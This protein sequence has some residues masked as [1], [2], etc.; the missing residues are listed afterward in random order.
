MISDKKLAADISERLL[1]VNDL[2]NEMANLVQKN[3]EESEL[4]PFCFA[5]ANVSGELLLGIA[6][7]LYR[8]HPEFK[9]QGM[10]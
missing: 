7:P 2:L 8:E 1:L 9:P 4:R 3:G 10:G 5:I 6:N